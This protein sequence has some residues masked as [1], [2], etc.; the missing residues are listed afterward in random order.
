M[1]KSELES[2]ICGRDYVRLEGMRERE[3]TGVE[4]SSKEGERKEKKRKETGG[5]S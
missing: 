1:S 5:S 3:K 2:R 4:E